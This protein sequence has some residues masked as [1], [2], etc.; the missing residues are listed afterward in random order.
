MRRTQ[1]KRHR[2]AASAR[3]IN[4][5]HTTDSQVVLNPANP[6]PAL[7]AGSSTTLPTL[8]PSVLKQAD[9]G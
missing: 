9:V 1:R 3:V 2:H 7:P 8:D 4:I 5:Y 6:V